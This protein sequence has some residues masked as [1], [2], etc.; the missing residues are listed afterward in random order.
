MLAAG[1]DR[2]GDDPTSM[3]LAAGNRLFASGA[4]S[5][6]SVIPQRNMRRFIIG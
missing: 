4:D 5:V 1:A 6:P 3:I 2:D